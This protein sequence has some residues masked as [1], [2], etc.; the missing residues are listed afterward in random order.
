MNTDRIR[1]FVDAL[2]GDEYVQHTGCLGRVHDDGTETNCASGVMCRVVLAHGLH[3]S[4]EVDRH[5]WG[6]KSFQVAYDGSLIAPSYRVMNW[7]GL[8]GLYLPFTDR[9]GSAVGIISLND[10]GFTFDQ[11]A[12]LVEHFWLPREVNDDV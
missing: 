7:F 1:L 12:D 9:N 5:R 11:I 10:T 6:N 2:R 3:I 8:A 4:R